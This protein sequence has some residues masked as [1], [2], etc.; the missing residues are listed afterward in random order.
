MRGRGIGA[1]AGIEIGGETETGPMTMIV[2]EIMDENVTV[3]GTAIGI[4]SGAGK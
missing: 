2:T 3:T 1:E 4:V